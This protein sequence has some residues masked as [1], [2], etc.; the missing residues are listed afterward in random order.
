MA[1]PNFEGMERLTLASTVK[2][3]GYF[4][5][6]IG[7]EPR[8]RNLQIPMVGVHLWKGSHAEARRVGEALGLSE[9]S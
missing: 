9:E 3:P 6:G 4:M 2:K 1:T 5:G 8:K 7:R